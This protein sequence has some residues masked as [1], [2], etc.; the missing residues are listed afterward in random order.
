MDST[1]VPATSS[2]LL[3]SLPPPLYALRATAIV[4]TVC[5]SLPSLSYELMQFL[6]F[7]LRFHSLFF[8][9]IR[10]NFVF[11][12]VVGGEKHREREGG[13]YSLPGNWFHLRFSITTWPLVHP[14]D[15]FNPLMPFAIKTFQAACQSF[16]P[17]FPF[18]RDRNLWNL[19]RSLKIYLTIN[20]VNYVEVTQELHVIFNLKDSLNIFLYISKVSSSRCLPVCGIVIIWFVV[21]A[22][23]AILIWFVYHAKSSFVF[24]F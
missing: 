23:C 14:L 9:F 19:L 3:P 20:M 18:F 17:Q 11:S 22:Y 1:L 21:F 8:L 4:H 13:E 5:L 10:V 15:R 24:H 16:F 6:E 7:F 2:L 12:H